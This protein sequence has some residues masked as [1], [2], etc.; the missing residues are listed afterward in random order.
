[1]KSVLLPFFLPLL[2]IGGC[3]QDETISIEHFVPDDP[4]QNCMV[5]V[6]STTTQT[7]GLLDVGIVASTADPGYTVFPVVKNNLNPS[8]S[9]GT[10]AQVERNAVTVTGAN[11]ELKPDASLAA[12]I[13]TN[14]RKFFV[15][16]AAGRVD[17]MGSVVFGIEAIP[18]PV[19]LEL[20]NVVMSGVGSVMPKVTASISPVGDRAGDTIV[21]KAQD[22]PIAIC[23]FCLSGPPAAC[24]AGGFTAADVKVGGCL[25]AQDLP[26]TCCLGAQQQLVCGS[27]VPMKTM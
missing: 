18:R 3:V 13:P 2:W 26:I 15:A 19:A 24:P 27:D 12:A 25:Q 20:A 1:M 10:T 14:Q 4:T 9:T 17:P 7:E 6:S 21:G 5:Q 11:V 22:F 8:M 23:K 16:A